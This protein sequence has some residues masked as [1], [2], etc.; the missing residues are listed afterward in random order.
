M[1]TRLH[2]KGEPL[3]SYEAVVQLISTTT[4]QTG[5]EI[6]VMLDETR[7]EGKQKLSRAPCRFNSSWGYNRR[8]IGVDRGCRAE[9]EIR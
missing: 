5:L 4:T 9:F 1:D 3:V 6:E 2:W 8:G 7:Y